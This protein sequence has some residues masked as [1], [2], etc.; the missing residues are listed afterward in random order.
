MTWS[1]SSR[2]TVPMNRSA[3]PF[4]QGLRYGER[5]RREAPQARRAHLRGGHPQR[6]LP[7]ADLRRRHRPGARRGLGP[8]RHP[9]G[10]HAPRRRRGRRGLRP[11]PRLHER[12]P[13]DGER[14]ARP[15]HPGLLVE[16]RLRPHRPRVRSGD[17]GRGG[18]DRGGAHHLGRRGAGP[19]PG[20]GGGGAGLGRDRAGGPLVERVVGTALGPITRAAPPRASTGSGASSRTRSAPRC[21]APSSR[22]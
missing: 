19:H 14:E 17:A 21:R 15:R 18:K 11:P 3:T 7:D 9:G 4:C 8:R 1:S 16:H 22:S 5:R 10:G 2:R 13:P 20:P 6:R 12:A